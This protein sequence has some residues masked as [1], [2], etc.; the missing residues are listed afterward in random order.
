M[1]VGL[2]AAVVAY[3]LT[4]T[5]YSSLPQLP[6]LAGVSAAILGVGEAV[7][8]WGLRQRIRRRADY[9]RGRDRHGATPAQPPPPPVPALLAARALAVG[10][11]SA[12]AGAAL[13]GLWVGFAAYVLPDA[14]EVT[15]AHADAVTASIGMVGS[16]VL[17]VG[18]LI[19][20]NCC[21]AQD[22]GPP[23]DGAHP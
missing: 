9:L 4:R 1:A 17:L 15:A 14:G 8:G 3:L 18:A 5:N 2:V 21:R 12:L 7:F 20:E 19:L 11:A 13:L 22:D 16:L 6:R 10:K 23:D